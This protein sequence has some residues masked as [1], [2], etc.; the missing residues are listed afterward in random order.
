[1][2]VLK[3]RV[4]H[5]L[6]RKRRKSPNQLS[7]WTEA[8]DARQS[9]W[10]RR[11][12][13]FNVWSQKKKME[14]LHYMHM[15][16]VKRGLV[17]DLNC[18]FGA[19][20]AFTSLARRASAT[21]TLRPCER[22]GNRDQRRTLCKKRKEC[23]TRKIRGK[24][25]A[26]RPEEWRTHYKRALLPRVPHP[27]TKDA[28]FADGAKSAAPSRSEAKPAPPATLKFSSEAWA[29]RVRHPS[30]TCSKIEVHDVCPDPDGKI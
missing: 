30:S 3:Q 19:A 23:G 10:Q 25:W 26:T 8:P 7:L 9:F 6:R 2:Q 20:I 4:S 17:T 27:P 13:D 5:A 1:M 11:F 12:Y 15:N 16:P 29:T 24:A 18:G 22:A 21:R 14:K 28:P